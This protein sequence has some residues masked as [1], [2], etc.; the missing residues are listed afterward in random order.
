MLSNRNP[1]LQGMSQ[2]KQE[3]TK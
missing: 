3:L 1:H 2:R